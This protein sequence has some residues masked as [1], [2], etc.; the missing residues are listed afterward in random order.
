LLQRAANQMR[1]DRKVVKM[2]RPY[3]LGV[4][5][6]VDSRSRGLDCPRR[7]RIRFDALFAV[8]CRTGPGDK[9][10]LRAAA[11]NATTSAGV[12]EIR[13][14]CDHAAGQ[15]SVPRAEKTT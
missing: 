15:G 12:L 10:A 5:P 3:L 11:R 14:W 1:H 8:R 13:N 4:H 2:R 6:S 9:R 7:A